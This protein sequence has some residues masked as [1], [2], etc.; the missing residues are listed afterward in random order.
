[1]TREKLVKI[2]YDSE[3]LWSCKAT[4]CSLTCR[5]CAEKQL[6][7]YEKQIR[8]SVYD[9]IL[10]FCEICGEHTSSCKGC[11]YLDAD[12]PKSCLERYVEELREGKQ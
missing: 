7:D 1:M 5:E 4:N 3:K 9:K 11:Q 10:D 8:E 12:N 6:S 2:I